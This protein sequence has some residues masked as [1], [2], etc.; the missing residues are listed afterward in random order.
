MPTLFLGI[1]PFFTETVA[2]TGVTGTKAAWCNLLKLRAR[3]DPSIPHSSGPMGSQ[4]RPTG[5]PGHWDLQY[6][7]GQA[8][9]DCPHRHDLQGFAPE[10]VLPF[11]VWSAVGGETG[12]NRDKAREIQNVPATPTPLSLTFMVIQPHTPH[13]ARR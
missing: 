3:L 1:S 12:N 6:S 8:D 10:L 7:P 5:R 9:I 2:D 4:K 11:H 13:L